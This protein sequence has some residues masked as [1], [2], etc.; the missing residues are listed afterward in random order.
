[1]L[2]TLKEIISFAVLQ[3]QEWGLVRTDV[4]NVTRSLGEIVFACIVY[5][6]L[7]WRAEGTPK[8]IVH[9][10]YMTG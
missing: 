3:K 4:E 7:M 9:I 1:M 2:S 10:L 8:D 5:E 6:I